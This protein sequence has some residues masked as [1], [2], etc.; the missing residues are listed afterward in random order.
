M[1]RSHRVCIATNRSDPILASDIKDSV[2]KRR[3]GPQAE[4]DNFASYARPHRPRSKRTGGKS[5]VA[6]KSTGSA[7]H[8]ANSADQVRRE[9][10][11]RV[12]CLS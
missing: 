11:L 8:P 5:A 7:L 9:L 2:E 3:Y 6:V 10:A 4:L 12:M 1:G